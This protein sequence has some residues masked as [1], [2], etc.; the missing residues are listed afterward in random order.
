M[1]N[2]IISEFETKIQNFID[3]YNNIS[4]MPS[5][6]GFSNNLKT[7]EIIRLSKEL[8]K[9]F[10]NMKRNWKKFSKLQ[11]NK[12]SKR[13]WYATYP[14]VKVLTNNLKDYYY[15]K[16]KIGDEL[17]V[18]NEDIIEYYATLIEYLEFFLGSVIKTWSIDEYNAM[19]DE[20]YEKKD[21]PFY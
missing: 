12:L 18:F 15:R 3:F 8:K 9:A 6:R 20:I 13:H 21:N 16:T 14:Y 2:I 4:K 19:I 17:H 10:N 1:V 7:F 11:W 5:R